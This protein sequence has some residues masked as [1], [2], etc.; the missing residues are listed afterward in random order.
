M[1]GSN[2]PT[3]SY[4]VE[5]M[6]A[7]GF[8]RH[9]APTSGVIEAKSL[10]NDSQKR[11]KRIKYSPIIDPEQLNA[12]AIFELS[13]SPCIYFTQL[14]QSNPDP[15]KLARLHQIAWNH[16]LAPMLWVVTPSKVLLYNCYSRPKE[17]EPNSPEKHLIEIFQKT[18]EGLKELNQYASRLQIESGEFW[19]WQKAKH[20]DRKQ[21][22]D[23]VL[24]KDLTDAEEILVTQNNLK[25]SVAQALLI[26]SIFLAYLQ[27][28][29]ILTPNF[30]KGNFGH[31][32][33]LLIFDDKVATHDLFNWVQETFNGDLL[34]LSPEDINLIDFEHLEVVKIFVSGE[35]EIRTGQR[36]L[37]KAY[38]FRVIPVELIST[39][40]EKFIY[41]E[42]SKSAR[43][44]STHYTPLN[45]VDLL[46][47]EVFK[48]LD[49]DAKVLDLACGSGVFLV[50]ALRRLV[51]KRLN[52][53]EE[54]SRQLIRDTLYQQIY[55]V[56]INEQAVQIATFSLYLTALELDYELEQSKSI[57]ED[58]KFQK[59][60]NT[61]LFISDAFDTSAEFN[62]RE[63]FEK[64]QFSAIVG[65]PPWTKSKYT[66][67]ASEYCK[68]KRPEN[69]YP[70]GYPTAYGTPPDQAFLWRIG[71]F[72]NS[73]TL[74]GLI[75]DGKRFFSNN[76]D[77]KKAKKALLTRYKPKVI[78][79]LLK[80]YREKLFPNS[81]APPII[82]IAESNQ[83]QPQDSFYFVCPERSVNFRQHGI[84]EIGAENIKKLSVHG[85]A[86]D[87]DMLKVATWGTARDL[88]LIQHLQKSYQ[89]IS[90]LE[91][92]LPKAGLKIGNK[93]KNSPE[94][95]FN[96][97]LL[98]SGEMSK[99]QIDVDKLDYFNHRKVESPRNPCIYRGP[100]VV[101]AEKIEDCRL[102][103]AFSSQDVVYTMSYSGIS[104]S[105]DNLAHYI[106][107][108]LNSS[109]ASYFLFMTAS[110]WGVERKK[111]MTQ[112]L[113]RLPV[114]KL[115]SVST[116][117]VGKLLEVE[118]KLREEIDSETSEELLK[119]E[120]DQLVFQLYELDEMEQIL[121]EDMTQFTID[122]YMNREKSIALIKPTF[123]QLTEYATHLMKSIEP[124]LQTLNERT[125]IA[126]IID[127]GKAPLQVIKFSLTSL[128]RRNL[129]VEII[130]GQKLE[131]VL[132]SIA[133]Q[134]PQKVADSIYTRRDLRIYVGED[135]Y[136]IKPAKCIYWTRSQGF[137]DADAILSESLKTNY[138]SVR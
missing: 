54:Y 72:T 102:S 86:D 81:E 77:A 78:I 73:F 61:N 58:L 18:E 50:D 25:R 5:V 97:K 121:V 55:G 116:D 92:T 45:L 129:I 98:S 70:E 7:A 91:E 19:Q 43:E 15:E 11:D 17:T 60:I 40:Y 136:I 127:I 75:V 20:I 52:S 110:S 109:V 93:S 56:D 37:W 35:Q 16:G 51:V 6:E 47:S 62:S 133:Q 3:T 12:T 88:S 105:S 8:Y 48:T 53:G 69:G 74:M 87:P 137:N 59:L 106:N 90:E 38:N 120:L 82:L 95:L 76:P 101:I 96:K 66:Q 2:A 67:S 32:N 41:A 107:A 71:D 57:S 24:V 111:I 1:S 21:R 89:V 103:S 30:L 99:Y 36:R 119:Q 134:L 83:A 26:Q 131:A 65:N 34:T 108:I 135:I 113:S 132:K 94:Y 13:G 79:N 84:I 46:L 124:F 31:D 10:R 68:R 29:D 122:F 128:P 123:N 33:L 63:P 85:A 126:D 28:R 112:D 125:I 23:E 115:D 14:E 138:A 39:I 42:D 64:K 117:L 22:V 104:L 100:L 118:R 27:D 80:L 49:G 4:F 114:P 130:P 44:H 9:S